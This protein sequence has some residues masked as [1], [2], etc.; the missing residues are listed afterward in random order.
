VRDHTRS[1]GTS[2]NEF[3]VSKNHSRLY[4]HA[5]RIPFLAA[6]IILTHQS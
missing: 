1:K 5:R 2:A 6:A 4:V 3:V